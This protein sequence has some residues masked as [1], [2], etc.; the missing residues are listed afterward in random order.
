MEKIKSL[1]IHIPFCDHICIYCDFYKM[2]ANINKQNEYLEYLIKELEIRKD[3][4][5]NLETIYIGGGT[6]ST[7]SINNLNKL[8][9]YLS[10]NIN[11]DNIKEFSIECNPKDINQDLINLFKLYHVNRI[12]LGIQSFDN[13]KLKFLNRNHDKDIAFNAIKLLQDNDFNN[14]NVDII[15]GLN[16]DNK[17]LVKND[18]DTLISLGIP[19]IS[20][21]TLII[22][23]KTILNRFISFGYSPLS[24]DKEAEIYGFVSKYLR[25]FGYNHY[26]ISNF[27]KNGYESIHNLCYWDYDN[28]IGV[29]ANA[30]GKVG[31][32]RYTNINNL[33]KYY[34]G[35]INN[36][37]CYKEYIDLD[38]KDLMDEYIMMGLRKING[39]NKNIFK[40]RFN[41]DIIDEYNNINLL[42]NQGLLID[43]DNYIKIKEDKIYIM[44]SIL[45]KIL[46]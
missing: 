41:C 38:K 24:D 30:S 25:D 3:D 9:S 18:L 31:N 1:Y 5:Q 42:I 37:L 32:I 34:Q 16:N 27:A 43:K 10:N 17:E 11:L 19:H 39:I 33:N 13:D 44:N 26:E 36:N 46:E 29:G 4:L 12:S 28:Y 14:I 15:F 35:I 8:L 45:L 7:L 40:N 23:D 22:E 2:I 20:V 6:P 21:Y